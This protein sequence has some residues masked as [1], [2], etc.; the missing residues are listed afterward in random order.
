MLNFKNM[1]LAGCLTPLLAAAASAF[2]NYVQAFKNQY[3]TTTL[4]TTNGLSAV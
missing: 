2:P 1:K 3:P 4:D